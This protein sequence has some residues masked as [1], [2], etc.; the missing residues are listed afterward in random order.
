MTERNL[1]D[2]P[3][4]AAYTEERDRLPETLRKEYDSLVHWYR[5]LATRHY[6]HPFVSYKILADLIREGWRQS[7]DSIE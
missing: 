3:S 5:Y 4:S 6:S 2:L 7:A 1:G